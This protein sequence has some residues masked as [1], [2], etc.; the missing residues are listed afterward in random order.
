LN[1]E[2]FPYTSPPGGSRNPECQREK[3]E[4]QQQNP[5]AG[6]AVLNSKFVE[7]SWEIID[8]T[9]SQHVIVNVY[10]TIK[11][12]NIGPVTPGLF[13][14]KMIQKLPGTCLWFRG[15]GE[16]TQAESID[17]VT[18]NTVLGYD[19]FP[20]ATATSPAGDGT[21][22]YFSTFTLV[23]HETG[24][25]APLIVKTGLISATLNV[26]K[27]I[28][29]SGAVCEQ[30]E[31]TEEIGKTGKG[32]LGVSATTITGTS[33]LDLLLTTK[34]NTVTTAGQTIGTLAYGQELVRLALVTR[35]LSP[36]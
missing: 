24:K 18:S 36:L 19:Y 23:R 17:P 5:V 16:T 30:S 9:G 29:L 1:Y 7:E 25:A 35:G 13:Y 33:T 2:S 27:T 22:D 28:T 3:N 10:P 4:S 26:P 21:P 20:D 34:A 15:I 31:D 11:K 32:D 14:N 8:L 6:Q 12:F